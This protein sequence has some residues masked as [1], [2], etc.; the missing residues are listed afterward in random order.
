MDEVLDRGLARQHVLE[1]MHAVVQ[2]AADVPG[3]GMRSF[4]HVSCPV[5]Q[6]FFR[7]A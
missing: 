3:G 6:R 4:A 5:A 2:A 7:D 1:V